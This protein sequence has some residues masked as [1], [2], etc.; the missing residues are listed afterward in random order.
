MQEII[1]I[2]DTKGDGSEDDGTLYAL[3]SEFMDAAIVLQKTPPVRVNYSSVAYYLLGHSAELM[4]KAFLYKNGKTIDDLIKISHDL[5]K[6]VSLVRENGLPEIVQLNQIRHLAVAYKD[7]S[8][9]YRTKN[10]KSFP[11]IDI[12][13]EEIERLQAAVFDK[14]WD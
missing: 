11:P 8:F 14:L 3:S 13:I 6:L 1:G 7:K 10:K 4:L 2:F 9:E 5:E 12:L